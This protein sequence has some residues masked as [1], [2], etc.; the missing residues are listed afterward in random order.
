M[1]LNVEYR[2][3]VCCP[4]LRSFNPRAQALAD[5]QPSGLLVNKAVNNTVNNWRGAKLSLI[6]LTMVYPHT[7]WLWPKRLLGEKSCLYYD[8]R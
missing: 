2:L 6:Q 5:R 7:S 8:L 4:L 3:S 1:N